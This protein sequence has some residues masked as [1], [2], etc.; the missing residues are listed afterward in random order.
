MSIERILVIESDE[1]V[2]KQLT[3]ALQ[4]RTGEVVVASDL[5][6]AQALLQKAPFDLAITALKLPDGS[7]ADLLDLP[8]ARFPRPLV[9]VMSAFGS[10]ESAVDCLRRGAFSC[11]LKPFSNEQLDVTLRKADD[12]ARLLR[13]TQLLN[14]GPDPDGDLIGES[15][16]LEQLRK[17]V[18]KVARTDASV[19]VA[20][21]SGTGKELV[22]R[23]IHRQ[24]P[25][26]AGPFLRVACAA[27][28]E[29]QLEA[30]LF[31]QEKSPAGRREG[32]FE[33][34]RGGTLLLDEVSEVPAATQAKLIRALEEQSIERLGGTRAVAVDVRVLATTNRSL[35]D[36]V[37]RDEFREDL[38]LRLNI[39]PVTVPTLRD[40][41]ADI[42]L[43]AEHFRVRYARKHGV[44]AL[45]ISPACLAALQNYDWPGNVRELQNVIER[46]VLLC[47]AGGLLEPSHLDA[48]ISA[49]AP[50]TDAPPLLASETETLDALEKKHILAV[51]EKCGGNRTRAAVR[52]GISIRTLRNKLHEYRLA[53]QNAAPDAESTEASDAGPTP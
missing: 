38:F 52:L 39:V 34:A 14:A 42:P 24:S 33:L 36:K 7:A 18:R 47:R 25:R 26:A 48:S 4:P 43:L 15:S 45:A 51:L 16:A 6:A 29:S 32:R 8:P 53:A 9:V 50:E 46:A 22:A 31:G 28:S 23:L 21:E 12:H 44:N 35:E 40:R 37:A 1:V 5:A 17:T 13:V 30:E 3:Q 19:L 10:V 49:G 27:L 2:R 11:L 41:K 20:G